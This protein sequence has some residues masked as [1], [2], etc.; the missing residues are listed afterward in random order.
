MIHDILSTRKGIH[1]SP[2]RKEIVIGLMSIECRTVEDFFKQLFS[3]SCKYTQSSLPHKNF[4]LGVR[5]KTLRHLSFTRGF[6]SSL[7]RLLS[8]IRNRLS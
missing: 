2:E 1:N 3:Q 5:Y 8:K 7:A 4:E 6:R